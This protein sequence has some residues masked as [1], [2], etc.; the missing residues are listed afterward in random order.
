MVDEGK[1]KLGMVGKKKENERTQEN[2]KKKNDVEDLIEENVG[3]GLDIDWS[4]VDK[5][6]TLY[7]LSYKL[8]ESEIFELWEFYKIEFPEIYERQEIPNYFIDTFVDNLDRKGIDIVTNYFLETIPELFQKYL[9][10][11]IV[12]SPD[13]EVKKI[14]WTNREDIEF[15]F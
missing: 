4:K 5:R 15:L 10:P 3:S 8:V 2:I 14:D 7:A 11:P 9:R 12:L 1:D 13:V 6:R